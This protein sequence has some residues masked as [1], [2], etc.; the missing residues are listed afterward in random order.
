[1]TLPD[2]NSSSAISMIQ[3]KAQQWINAIRNG[4][5]HCC[6]VLFLLKI[7]FFHRI[8][9]GLCSSTAS[10]QELEHAL[11]R[12]YYQ[13]LP[14]GGIVCTVTVRS[15]TL[16]VGFFGVGLP[17]LGVE[18]LFAMSNKLLIHYGCQT[19]IGWFMQTSLSLLFV[20]L[21][22]SFQPLQESYER[23]GF[24]VTHFWFKMLWEKLFK[25]GM[26]VVVADHAI[27]FSQE[28]NQFIMQVLLKQNYPNDILLHLNHMQEYLQLLFMSDILTASGHK[29]NPEVL[30]H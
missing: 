19:A 15:R 11:H 27:T 22:L 9:Y 16:D 28:G 29:I 10:F 14:L 13:I 25:S 12:P 18:A 30:S 3:E 5:L 4:H 6:N 21:G 1:M 26:K 2:D 24:M 7:K 17:H 20:E 23:F 8:S